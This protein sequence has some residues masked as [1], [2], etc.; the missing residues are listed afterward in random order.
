MSYRVKTDSFEGPFDLLLYLVARQKV[1]IGSIAISEIADQ[2]L[3]EVAR[4]KKVDLDVAS[5][6]LLVAATL[7]EMKAASLI[8]GDEA[9]VVDDLEE[10]SPGQMRDVLV[11]RL[12]EYKKFK[13]AAVALSSLCERQD[14][15]HVRTFGPDRSMLSLMPDYLKGTSLEDLARLC[16]GCFAHRDVFLLQSE[17]IARRV[18]SLEERASDMLLQVRRKGTVLFSDLLGEDANDTELVVVSFL[19]LLE[20]FKRRKVGLVQDELFGDILV[21]CLEDSSADDSELGEDGREDDGLDVVD[22]E[23]REGR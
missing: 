22:D 8:P 18:V 3:S 16:A 12:V 2:Y 10:L 21:S 1:D 11:E 13:N 5:D 15:L 14:A 7:L 17:H 6:F 19:S 4:M 20:L 9:E 23:E